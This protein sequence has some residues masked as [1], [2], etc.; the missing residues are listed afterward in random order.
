M[1][2]ISDVV[3]ITS[4]I[5]PRGELRKTFGVTLFVTTDED[6][7]GRDWCRATENLH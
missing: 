7:F 3:R 5:V 1:P 2:E 4:S 6:F